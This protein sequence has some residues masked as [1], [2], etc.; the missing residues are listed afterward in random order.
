MLCSYTVVAAVTKLLLLIFSGAVDADLLI[1]T[2]SYPGINR[3]FNYRDVLDVTWT[4]NY[5]DQL[6]TLWCDH[7][8]SRE[9]SPVTTVPIFSY[10]RLVSQRC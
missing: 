2:I 7:A 10:Q 1:A 8:S 6:L 9:S 4:S 3:N 5:A